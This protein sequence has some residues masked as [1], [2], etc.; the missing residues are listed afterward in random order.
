MSVSNRRTLAGSTLVVLAVLFLAVVMLSS[1]LFRG[2]RLDLTRHGLYTVSDGTEAIL[3]KIEEPI[4]LTY[5][6]SDEAA[7]DIPQ[8]RTYATRVRELLEEIAAKSGG[9][10]NLEVVDPVP[11]SEQED[12]ATAAGLQAVPLGN[13]GETL[14]FGLVGTNSTDGQ[15]VIPFFQPDKEQFLEYD[16]AKLISSLSVDEQPVVGVLSG[17]N[18]SPGFDPQTGPTQGWTIDGELR[19]LFDVQ[20]VEP[21]ATSIPDNM[22][23]LVLVHPKNLP[24]DTLY[25]IDQFVL[26]GGH[27][28]AFVDPH[29]ESEQAGQ[30][31]DPTQA[32]FEDKS[33]D[34]AR[35]FK[36]WGVRYDAKQ[37]LLD[38]RYALEL[39]SSPDRPPSRHLEVIGLRGGG[40]RG[41]TALNAGD[42]ISAD[43]EQINLSSAGAFD[44]AD[45]AV[46]KLEP[47]L[48][49]SDQAMTVP[50]E[51]VRMAQQNPESLFAG[52]KPG[53]DR[54]TIA[55]R[56]TGK[57]KTA[58][59]ERSGE[60]HLAEAKDDANVV[61]V[62]DTDL[63][64]DRLWVQVQQFFGQR[65]AN[66]FA[67]NGDLVIN[68]VDN[69][70][71]SGDLIS[72][73]TRPG[74]AQPFDTVDDLKRA[75]DD[76]FRA[77]EQELQ[78]E[79]NETEQKLGQLQSQ[80]TDNRSAML[81][82]PEQQS[83]LQRFQD[84]KLR[85]RKELRSVRR[86][87]DADIESLGSKLKFLNIA[88]VPIVLTVFALFWLFARSRR[89][90]Q[91]VA[92]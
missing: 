89:R 47:L 9:K 29:A 45:D 57:L 1:V 61:L 67:N 22:K 64:T 88:G 63:L 90:K 80:K 7:R 58:F 13:S 49:S 4:K 27:L 24:D 54:Y 42:V 66:A 60:S 86:Q 8:L 83:E 74:A 50:S 75:A 65:I 16:V 91:E 81:L 55:G 56:L 72:V 12:R 15:V 35:L 11:F 43:L 25:A 70:V 78:A 84:Q 41:E 46:G 79:L 71:G 34:L 17:L 40:E 52:F 48:Q 44:L 28:L 18:M 14:F 77:K 92:G 82:S 10:V 20:R 6:Y 2:A 38:A 87:L 21:N 53:D 36:A 19:K 30:G 31:T 85:I 39:Q 23:A 5:Y 33:S 51:R 73:R 3:G 68:A 69:L 37:V 59:P 32:M 62:A 76:R 26:R